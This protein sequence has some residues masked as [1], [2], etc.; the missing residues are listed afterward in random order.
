MRL[1][2]LSALIVL[3]SGGCTSRPAPV[4]G[5]AMPAALPVPVSPPPS[6][7]AA[8]PIPQPDAVAVILRVAPRPLNAELMLFAV[9]AD[10]SLQPFFRGEPVVGPDTNIG[11]VDAEREAVLLVQAPGY[12]PQAFQFV[13]T[14]IA[15]FFPTLRAL[16]ASGPVTLRGENEELGDRVRHLLEAGKI[17][18]PK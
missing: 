9:N 13:F 12:I 2:F 16:P 17:V 1:A 11:P 15:D 5:L 3:L 7:G 8:A 4:A 14:R 18:D 10:D 6:A